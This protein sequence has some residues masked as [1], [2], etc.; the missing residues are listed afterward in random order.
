VLRRGHPGYGGGVM[1]SI[2]QWQAE[3]ERLQAEV[4]RLG[5]ASMSGPLS[6][7]EVE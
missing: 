1:I 7:A 3:N 5:G 4:E 2:E 6:G